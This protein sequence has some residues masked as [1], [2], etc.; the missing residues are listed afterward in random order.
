MKISGN[1]VLIT[2]GAT[3]IGLALAKRFLKTGNEVIVCGRRMEKLAAAKAQ[4]PNLQI[5]VC[6]VSDSL[7]RESL[8]AWATNEFPEL[9]V[10]VNN[11]GIQQR[12]NLAESQQDW[13]YYHQEIAANLEAPIHL[14][15][16]F[17]PHFM[18]KS[19]STLINVS[20]RLAIAPAAWVPIYSVTKAALHSFTMSL[21]LQLSHT[22]IEV[23]EV[24]PP[25]VNTDLGGPG[26]HTFGA[27]L[28]DFADVVFEGLKS[29]D[30][31][32]EFGDSEMRK[33]V[34]KEEIEKST[35]QMWE[36]FL[37]SNS[38]F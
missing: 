3:G 34:L 2:G 25:A 4:F 24:L 11:A 12:I 29:N 35:K 5:R 7:E 23:V 13:N 17:L 22:N 31:E 37:S 21:R 16:L 28:D 14:S 27:P 6:D 18:K 1:T 38:Q 26:L 19:H 8:V 33:L 15:T 36:H 30:L 10:L 9:N 20:S 32:I